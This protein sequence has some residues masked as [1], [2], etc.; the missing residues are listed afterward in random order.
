MRNWKEGIKEEKTAGEECNSSIRNEG[1]SHVLISTCMSTPLYTCPLP[2]THSPLH[3][4]TPLYTLPSTHTT[5]ACTWYACLLCFEL[6]LQCATVAKPL[7][8]MH[9]RRHGNNHMTA[10]QN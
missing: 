10:G 6:D 9:H 4:S 8:F 7:E 5:Q 2:S 1:V 3:M